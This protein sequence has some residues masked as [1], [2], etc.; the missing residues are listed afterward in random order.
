MF[1]MTR[2][3]S[4]KIC[5]RVTENICGKATELNTSSQAL[6]IT[7]HSTCRS[8]RKKEMPYCISRVAREMIVSK[9]RF[10]VLHIAPGIAI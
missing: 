9:R 6:P 2:A 1:L 3:V 5:E 10:R 4:L 8:K 7:Y